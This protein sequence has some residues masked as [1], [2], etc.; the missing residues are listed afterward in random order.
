[1]KNEMTTNEV[2]DVTNEEQ[3]ESEILVMLADNGDHEYT[4]LGFG[5]DE[6]GLYMVDL[7]DSGEVLRE[8]LRLDDSFSLLGVLEEGVGQGVFTKKGEEGDETYSYNV[9]TDGQ[10]NWDKFLKVVLA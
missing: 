5:E 1:M 2:L 9:E 3:F 7:E 4:R 8:K 10:Q 6:K